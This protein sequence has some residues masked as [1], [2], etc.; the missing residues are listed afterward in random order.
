MEKFS[1]FMQKW[2]YEKDGYYANYKAIGKEG[3]FYTSVSVSKF[4]GGAIAKHLLYLIENQKLSKRVDIFEIGAHK[5]YLLADII[6]FIY[7]L[8]PELLKTL[9][10]NIIE[11]FESLQKVQKEYFKNSFGD[12]IILNHFKSLKEI[13]SKEAFVVANEI[14]DAFPCELVYKEDMA[15]VENFKI[16]FFKKDSYCKDIS[17]RYRIERGEIAKGYEEFSQNLSNAFDRC[18][19]LTFDYGDLEPRNDFSI[20]IYKNHSV[21]PLFEEGLKLKDYYKKSDITYD[22]NF[23]H[24]IDAFKESSFKKDSFKTQL[25]ALVDFG[26]VEL[27]EIVKEKRGFEAYSKEMNKIKN[28]IHPS[29]MGERF[30]MVS[31]IK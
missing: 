22:V 4:F 13:N 17:K 26:I 6:E 30:K 9:T 28:L 21:K 3:D 16:K 8:K 15:Y 14:F 1:S 24:L 29:I 12:K 18:Y 10:F 5:G 20:R 31:F 25:R 2:L 7:T 23:S 11:P 27:L 19:F